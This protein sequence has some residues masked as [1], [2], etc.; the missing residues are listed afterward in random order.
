MEGCE[1]CKMLVERWDESG[2]GRAACGNA[3][4]PLFVRGGFVRRTVVGTCLKR[5]AVR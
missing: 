1:L 3:G 5:Q 2:G 4:A